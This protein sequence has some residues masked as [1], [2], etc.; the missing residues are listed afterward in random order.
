METYKVGDKVY[1]YDYGW[2]KVLEYSDH[3]S[4]PVK[5]NFPEVDA[6]IW[7]T[8]DGRERHIQR[9]RVL[10]FT[11][12]TLQGFSQERP[13]ELPE[14]GELCLV[15]V[16]GVNWEVRYFMK[17]EEGYFHTRTKEHIN[18]IWNHLK[19]IKVLD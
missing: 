8:K 18:C 4:T 9:V 14:V 16:D 7:F 1:H 15:S 13:I 6:T 19:R 10:S 3:G 11:E 2:G 5:V 17:Y 12:Y